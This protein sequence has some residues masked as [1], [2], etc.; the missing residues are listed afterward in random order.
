LRIVV[1][2]RELKSGVVKELFRNKVHIITEQLAIGD[3]ILGEHVVC[4]RKGVEDFVNSLLD[5]R[6]FK[7]VK[8]LKDAYKKPFLIIEGTRDMY[9][10]R[11]V[12]ANAI[13]GAM[14]SLALDFSLPIIFTKDE[15]DTAHFFITILKREKTDTQ[16][17]LRAAPKPLTDVELMEY[18]VS[19]FPGVGR[20][21]AQNILLQFKTIHSFVTS[22]HEQLTSVEGVG[23]ITAERIKDIIQ[24]R[25][26][27]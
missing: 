8:Q 21:T 18:I 1:D 22:E 7:Q 6:L 15:K 23:K 13:R 9:S 27:Q 14:A 24:K 2:H 12:H 20:R 19:S 17:N 11:N 10:V 16:A 26:K 3:F 5:G 25:Y 4:E